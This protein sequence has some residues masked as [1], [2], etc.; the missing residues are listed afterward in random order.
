MKWCVAALLCKNTKICINSI[1]LWQSEGLAVLKSGSSLGQLTSDFYPEVNIHKLKLGRQ[2]C[3][4]T[5][6]MCDCFCLQELQVI[7]GGDWWRCCCV[8]R[9]YMGADGSG[10]GGGCGSS[11]D[12]PTSPYLQRGGLCSQRLNTFWS[13]ANCQ[14]LKKPR[15]RESQCSCSQCCC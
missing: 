15:Q 9:V 10:G 7:H 8:E 5:N 11:A 13:D 6:A 12:A 4:H 14:G 1:S 3:K 2:P